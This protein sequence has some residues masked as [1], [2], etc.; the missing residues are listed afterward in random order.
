[1]TEDAKGLS[2]K[3][4]KLKKQAEK[5]EPNIDKT[6]EEFNYNVVEAYGEGNINDKE[7]EGVLNSY[8][9]IVE[10]YQNN[11]SIRNQKK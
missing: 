11:C 7:L 6:A 10:E 9:E 4:E 1:M 3:L 2:K 5:C 8:S